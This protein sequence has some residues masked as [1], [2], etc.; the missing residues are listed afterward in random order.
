MSSGS[1]IW[2]RF[3]NT[4]NC[5]CFNLSSDVMSSSALSSPVGDRTAS[6][7][8]DSSRW[9]NIEASG[10]KPRPCN[11]R[12]SVLAVGAG[13]AKSSMPTSALPI[14][15]SSLCFFFFLLVRSPP[16]ITDICF[17]FAS[18][19][20]SFS[21]IKRTM[22]P[23]RLLLWILFL[24]KPIPHVFTNFWHDLSKFL[25]PCRK[26]FEKRSEAYTLSILAQTT[27][28]RASLMS[29]SEN[30][31]SQKL[32]WYSVAFFMSPSKLTSSKRSADLRSL[33]SVESR[34][35]VAARAM[36]FLQSREKLSK[37]TSAKT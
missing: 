32:S 37:F 3:S 19:L 2:V 15:F 11:A 34:L 8:A 12:S 4:C 13:A 28:F 22:T 5:R 20:C 26:H 9:S 35:S 31:V 23:G 7:A 33:S 27:R 1:S 24:R 36:F 10:P 6:V 30:V 25:V 18:S 21:V 16:L 17:I 14:L 29:T